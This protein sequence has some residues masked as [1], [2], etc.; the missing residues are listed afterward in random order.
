MANTNVNLVANNPVNYS[1]YEQ[2]DAHLVFPTIYQ[3]GQLTLE[4]RKNRHPNCVT[5]NPFYVPDDLVLRMTIAWWY[6]LNKAHGLYGET[7]S[8]KTEM[9]YYIA[10]KL[11]EPVY[12]LQVHKALLPEVVEGKT[13]LKNGNTE[14]VLG[15]L[16]QGYDSNGDGGLVII[17]E[18]D[19]ANEHLQSFFHPVMERK[20]VSVAF[21]SQNILPHEFARIACTANTLGDGGSEKYSTSGKLDDALRSRI[22]WLEVFYPSESALRNIL[23]SKYEDYLPTGFRRDMIKL[24]IDIQ[25]VTL[26][27]D[28]TINAVFSTR[29]LIDWADSIL[30]FGLNAKLSDSLWYVTRGSCDKDDWT[31]FTSVCQRVLGAKLD[32]TVQKVLESYT[33]QP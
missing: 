13:T 17:D 14:D 25:K 20:P 33:P 7:G 1:E 31:S 2:V 30:A 16:L 10:D 8:G 9:L 15:T 27:D 29:T 3:P 6:S 18:L 28:R 5:S 21:S 19:K 11:N 23:K 24:A 26:G 12:L 4:R 32:D 22:N